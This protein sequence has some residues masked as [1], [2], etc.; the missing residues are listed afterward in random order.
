MCFRFLQVAW[1]FYKTGELPHHEHGF[2]EG[3]EDAE[4]IDIV[5]YALRTTC[6]RPTTGAEAVMSASLRFLA[7][8]PAAMVVLP[9]L[10]LAIGLHPNTADHLP[11]AFGLMLTGMPISISL[12]LTVLTFLFTMTTVPIT[13][14]ALKL[15]TGI[16]QLRDDGDPVLHPCRQLPDPRRRC[17]A[18]DRVRVIDGWTLARW[19]RRSPA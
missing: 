4:P 9:M 18:N 1:S 13:S 12:G 14:V 16:E 19:A 5:P 6:T 17:A 10:G 15:F 7:S 11:P 2:V 3:I 8:L